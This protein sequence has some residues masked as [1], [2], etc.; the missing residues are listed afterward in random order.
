MEIPMKAQV[1]CTDGICGRSAYVLMN[2][3]I[4]EST[5][6]VVRAN[7]LPHTRRAGDIKWLE[8]TKRKL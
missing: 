3:V 1:S 6:L 2:P 4:E 8:A 5:H 7:A